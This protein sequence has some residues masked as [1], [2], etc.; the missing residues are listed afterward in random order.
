MQATGQADEEAALSLGASGCKTFFTGDAAQRQMGASLRRAS[1]QR[2]RDGRIRR[3]VGGFRPHPRPHQHHAAAGRD[4]VQRLQY[5]SAFAVASLLALLALVT[6]GLKACFEALSVSSP[7][8]PPLRK[9]AGEVANDVRP[10]RW[11]W[12]VAMA[13]AVEITA[14]RSASAR[15][16]L[17]GV[18]LTIPRASWSRSSVLPARARRRSCAS[19]PGSNLAE[20]RVIFAGEDAPALRSRSGTRL[21]LPELRALPPYDGVRQ[22]RLRPDVRP[23][24]ARPRRRI[25]KR[26]MDSSTSSSSRAENRYPSQL[27]G[28]QR[29]RVALARALAIE[30]RMLLLDEPFGALDAKVRRDLRRWLRDIHDRT[31]HTTVFVTHDQDEAIELADRIVV[32][33]Q[34]QIEQVGTPDEIYDRPA[35]PFVKTFLN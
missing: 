6:L 35:T 16:V 3:G 4:S 19:L 30:P 18:D 28:G 10:A 22:H 25:R 14:R 29:Q 17:A 5:R 24:R 15:G 1:L 11:R 26:V 9:L 8:T 23:P 27:S 34:G 32:L 20:R 13:A 7:P 21:R 33:N 31:G 2:P 12:G